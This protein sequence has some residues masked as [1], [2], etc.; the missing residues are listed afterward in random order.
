MSEINT[1]SVKEREI[2]ATPEQLTKK[3]S[4]DKRIDR[5]DLPEVTA[6]VEIFL[7]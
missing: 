2:I 1:N 6:I 5:M 4:Y 7:Q 3:I